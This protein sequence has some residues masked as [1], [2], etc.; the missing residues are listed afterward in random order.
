MLAGGDLVL[1]DAFVLRLLR[2]ELWRPRLSSL[3]DEDSDEYEARR[4]FRELWR[5]LRR[6]VLRFARLD[7]YD[8]VDDEGLTD[9]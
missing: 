1:R 3:L 5:F 4:G 6:S 9:R 8:A 7:T 2:L